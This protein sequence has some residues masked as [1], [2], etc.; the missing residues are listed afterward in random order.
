MN[1]AYTFTRVYW[2]N[3]PYILVSLSFLLWRKEIRAGGVSNRFRL[4]LSDGHL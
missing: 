1:L 2:N 3:F 4:S